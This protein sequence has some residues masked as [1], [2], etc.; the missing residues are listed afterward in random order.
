MQKIRTKNVH[1]V[2]SIIVTLEKFSQIQ[3]DLSLLLEVGDDIPFPYSIC[4]DD[5]EVFL[6][7]LRKENCTFRDFTRFVEQRVKFYGSLECRDELEICG[8]FFY[9]K[10]LI[11]PPGNDP[12]VVIGS[13]GD[14]IFE[15]YYESDLGFVK[16]KNIV[17]K[18][19]G[20]FIKWPN[21]KQIL[22]MH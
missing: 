18:S 16:E 21:S 9:H 20:N 17:R 4:I 10:K 13:N 22:K 3:T 11:V 1:D 8:Q 15:N 5:L 19:S 14:E 6:M 7:T 12:V 2:F